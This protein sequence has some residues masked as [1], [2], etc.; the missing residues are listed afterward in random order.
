M[1]PKLLMALAILILIVNNYS[2]IKGLFLKKD[3]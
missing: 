1:T 2:S 3:P